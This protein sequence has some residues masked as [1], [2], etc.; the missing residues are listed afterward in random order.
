[1]LSRSLSNPR[2]TVHA[3]HVDDPETHNSPEQSAIGRCL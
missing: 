2:P 1:M 3:P